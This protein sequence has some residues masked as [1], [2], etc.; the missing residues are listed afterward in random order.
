MHCSGGC[1]NNSVLLQL[2]VRAEL[3]WEVHAFFSAG[4]ALKFFLS[5]EPGRVF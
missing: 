5:V 3:G 4:L 1:R 2:A